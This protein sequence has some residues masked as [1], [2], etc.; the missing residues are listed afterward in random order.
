M[1][2]VGKNI[3]NFANHHKQMKVPYIIIV[4]FE[5]LNISVEGAAMDPD[6]TNTSFIVKQ[7]PCSYCYI[8][9]VKQTGQF[10]PAV[11]IP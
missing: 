4:D 9:M 1:P 8:A 7:E 6:K 5:A 11:R 2:E 10:S 3:L